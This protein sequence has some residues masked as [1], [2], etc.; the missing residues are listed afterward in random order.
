[1]IHGPREELRSVYNRLTLGVLLGDSI[2]IPNMYTPFTL[3]LSNSHT[4][5]FSI[6]YTVSVLDL[7]SITSRTRI[8]DKKRTEVQEWRVSEQLSDVR[9]RR[10]Y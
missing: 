2:Y 4:D 5:S 1:M 10:G 7:G 6:S 9:W 3:L 8:D